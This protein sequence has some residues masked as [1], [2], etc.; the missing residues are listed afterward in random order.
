MGREQGA[1]QLRDLRQI[2]IDPVEL[3]VVE[4]LEL[5]R[6]ARTEAEHLSVGV[7]AEKVTQELIQNHTA[8]HQASQHLPIGFE[9]GE[10]VRQTCGDCFGRWVS[11]A[12]AGKE[13]T[14][15]RTRGKGNE[16]GLL[17]AAEIFN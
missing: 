15:E 2:D 6:Q 13:A 11:K 8:L 14:G 12:P 9:W 3:A 10:I 5:R 1:S 17:D 7:T 4:P 16:Q